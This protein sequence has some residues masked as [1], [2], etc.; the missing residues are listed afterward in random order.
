MHSEKW[1]E[2]DREGGERE[3]GSARGGCGHVGAK[4]CNINNYGWPAN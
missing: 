3:G 1:R 4:A 2:R